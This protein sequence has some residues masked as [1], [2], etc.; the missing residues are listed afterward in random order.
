MDCTAQ[1]SVAVG[2]EYDAVALHWP[3]AAVTEMFIGQLTMGGCASVTV[4]VKVQLLVKPTPSV[5]RHTTVFVPF[6]K[7]EPLGKPPVR[8]TVGGGAQLSKAVGAV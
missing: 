6:G 1:L 2:L 7:A 5:A 4:T 3:G 8:S